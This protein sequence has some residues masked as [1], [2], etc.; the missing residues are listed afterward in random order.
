MDAPA[1][2]KR[3]DDPLGA[4]GKRFVDYVLAMFDSPRR[5]HVPSQPA[6]SICQGLVRLSDIGFA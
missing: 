1:Q 5:P 2:R 3:C 4:R 6:H